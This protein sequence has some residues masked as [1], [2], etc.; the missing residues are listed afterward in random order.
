MSHKAKLFEMTEDILLFGSKEQQRA[1]WE[2]VTKA[3][4]NTLVPN[5]FMATWNKCS[6]LDWIEH[7]E[8]FK[9]NFT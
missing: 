4:P 5:E 2:W 1:V 9:N 3:I 7:K 6:V 8:I